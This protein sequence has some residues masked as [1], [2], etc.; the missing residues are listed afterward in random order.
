MENMETQQQ[1]KPARPLAPDDGSM[2]AI[3]DVAYYYKVSKQTVRRWMDKGL[4]FKK[5][6]KR[7]YVFHPAEVRNWDPPV[8]EL[9]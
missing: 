1:P 4:P 2:W 3:V 5:M 9:Q 6:G 8:E 7:M